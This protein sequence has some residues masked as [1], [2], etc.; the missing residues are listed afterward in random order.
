M[1]SLYFSGTGNSKFIA[2]LFAKKMSCVAH[3]IEEKL[4]FSQLLAASDTIAF[5]YPV[6]GSCVPKIM[7]D[8]VLAHVESLQGKKL[9]IFCT[10]G[11]F[12]GDGSRVFTDLLASIDYTVLYAEHFNMP[13]NICNF[14][15]FPMAN[16]ASVGRYLKGAEKKMNIVCKNLQ[17]G[18]IRKRGFFV[19]SR[20]L[21]LFLQRIYFR[22][23]EPVMAKDVRV[24]NACILCGK[25]VSACPT[26]NMELEGGHIVQKGSCTLCY[27]CVNLCPQKAITVLWHAPVKQQ[28][29]GPLR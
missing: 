26:R 18:V 7:R 27:R 9:I 6:Y 12:S 24:T 3:S 20:L 1:L 10:Q 2:E 21:G 13:N 19:G 15:L 14:F 29:A 28:Y 5:T 25:C 17:K 8:F 4:D 22:M 16:D 11:M 23:G